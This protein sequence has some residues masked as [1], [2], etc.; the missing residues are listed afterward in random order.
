[1]L[2][3]AVMVSAML[4][5]GVGG[6]SP[7]QPS[8]SIVV[9]AAALLKRTFGGIGDS[10]KAANAGASVD[11]DLASERAQRFVDLVTGEEGRKILTQAGFAKP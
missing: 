6:C 4:V 8:P 7:S 10:F 9:F 3:L 1:M 5:A 11:F 2:R